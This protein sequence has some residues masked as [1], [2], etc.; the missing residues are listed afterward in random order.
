MTPVRLIDDLQRLDRTP[1][2]D[3]PPE[4]P[5]SRA[6]QRSRPGPRRQPATTTV[7]RATPES[8]WIRSRPGLTPDQLRELYQEHG[9]ALFDYVWHSCHDRGLAEDIVQET[10][11]R[12]WQR[13]PLLDAGRQSLR[14]W[15]FVVSRHLLID[16]LRA[17]AARPT[18]ISTDAPPD[19]PG[20]GDL[21]DR[22]LQSWQMASALALLS[23]LHREVLVQ[24]YYL[25]RTVAQAAA[26]LDV[27]EG[28]VKSRAYCALR[29][30][31]VALDDLGVTP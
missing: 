14:G 18:E 4:P 21:A 17:R 31:R 5:P 13:A 28:T 27:P 2:V 29:A 24:V 15:L 9:Q 22:T 7:D 8:R 10:L 12:A 26:V 6:A 16:T 11:V 25:D 30:L 19:R 20:H 23:P 3:R 1:R